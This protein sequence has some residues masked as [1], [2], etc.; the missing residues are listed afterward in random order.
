MKQFLRAPSLDSPE[1]TAYLEAPR[2]AVQEVQA[3][4]EQRSAALGR[5]SLSPR[6]GSGGR[7]ATVCI[8][9]FRA[10]TS[11]QLGRARMPPLFLCSHS[12]L[13]GKGRMLAQ[14]VGGRSMLS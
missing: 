11:P 14:G 3:P 10:T 12:A 6:L 13:V 7:K 5:G 9:A 4:N 8:F 1:K 2:D